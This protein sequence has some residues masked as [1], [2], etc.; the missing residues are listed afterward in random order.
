MQE[1]RKLA[2][3]LAGRQVKIK[4]ENKDCAVACYLK[5]INFSG[6]QI[7]LVPRLA[8][9]RYIKFELALSEDFTLKSEAWVAWQKEIEGH[10]VYG[11]YFTKLRESDKDGIYKFVFHGAPEKPLTGGDEMEDRRI[12]QRFNVRFP[13]RLLDLTNGNEMPAETSNISAKGIGLTLKEPLAVNTPLEAWLDIRDNSGPIYARG[14]TVWSRQEGESGYRI[15]V[16]L[17]RAD[18]MGLSRILRV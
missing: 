11:L 2:R 7:I 8:V 5:D 13:A 17:E 6:M 14:L 1:R 9:S 16:D 4:L 12:F 3:W 15:G 18:L 10:N